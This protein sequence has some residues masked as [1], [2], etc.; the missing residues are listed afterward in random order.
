M[1]NM[2]S[3]DPSSHVVVQ[4]QNPIL[5]F[6]HWCWGR[7]LAWV[8]EKRAYS[9]WCPESTIL[10]DYA[11]SPSVS[12]V[13]SFKQAY[14]SLKDRRQEISW[15]NWA[16]S[17][18]VSSPKTV[19]AGENPC[20]SCLT[21]GNRKLTCRHSVILRLTSAFCLVFIM[22]VNYPRPSQKKIKITES[23][24]RLFHT[25]EISRIS[26]NWVWRANVKEF[27][28]RLEVREVTQALSFWYCT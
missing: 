27:K 25:C 4:K 14:Y 20:F 3:K 28:W 21:N 10:R 18:V 1:Q 8:L 6:S 23:T 5:V 15:E 24:K 19:F 22:K 7:I 11:Q 26:S 12:N 16:N 2:F 13:L 9:H 17:P